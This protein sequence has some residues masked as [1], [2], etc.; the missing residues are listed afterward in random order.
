MT[1]EDN[2]EIAAYC[3]ECNF[4]YIIT[5]VETT[6]TESGR[7]LQRGPCPECNRMLARIMKEEI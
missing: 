7:T 4:T 1:L 5:P 6:T 2:T 3:E